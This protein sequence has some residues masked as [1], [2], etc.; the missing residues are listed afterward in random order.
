MQFIY[1]YDLKMKKYWCVR[2]FYKTTV[3]M[4]QKVGAIEAH[5]PKLILVCN[6]DVHHMRLQRI[7]NIPL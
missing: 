4:L 5:C 1:K 6:E 3:N 7:I 2:E